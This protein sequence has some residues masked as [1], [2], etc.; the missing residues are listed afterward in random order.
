M[1]KGKKSVKAKAAVPAARAKSR[2]VVAAR[3]AVT[4]VRKSSKSSKPTWWT[5][6]IQA[7]WNTDKEAANASFSQAEGVDASATPATTRPAIAF[8]YGAR[9]AYV[10]DTLW[11]PELEARLQADWQAFGL[12]ALSTW[13]SARPTVRHGWECAKA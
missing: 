7:S 6:A 11:G 5:D 3:P 9:R 4:P 1:I 10:A 13:T 12:E 2:T 8:G